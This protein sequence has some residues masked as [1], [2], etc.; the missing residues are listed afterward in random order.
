MHTSLYCASQILHFYRLKVCG[1]S[2]LSKS[3]SAIF[4]TAF[5]QFMPLCHILVISHNI[6]KFY[7]CYIY[8]DD[9]DC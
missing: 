7:C 9:S 6:S 5:T 2:A 4:P 1:N 8:Y 3:V